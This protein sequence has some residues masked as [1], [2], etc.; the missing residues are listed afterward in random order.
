MS[1]N[2]GE[3]Q[4]ELTDGQET[5]ETSALEA[6]YD[7]AKE[8]IRVVFHEGEPWYSVVDVVGLLTDSSNPRVYW[9]VLKNQIQTE[10]GGQLFR[11]SKQLKQLRMLATD[12]KMRL[13]DAAPEATVLRIIQSVPSPKAEPFKHWLAEVGHAFLEDSRQ[14]L[15]PDEADSMRREYQ[16]LGYSDTWIDARLNGKL[17]RDNLTQEWRERGL[18]ENREF[19]ILTDLLHKLAFAV[20]TAQHRKIK[21]IGAG[22]PLHDSLDAV[23]TAI[24]TLTEATAQRLHIA[25]DSYGFDELQSDARQ[26][27]K[28]GSLARLAFEAE[29]GMPVV[30]STNYKTLRQARQRE[31]QLPLFG[32]TL[33]EPGNSD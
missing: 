9:G 19:A 23:E 22:Q 14:K 18:Q 15:N 16:R 12:G 21:Q 5:Q 25:H 11:D 7:Q 13:T 26:A 1:D 30:N 3:S 32:E 24:Q 27:G 28:V 31:L 17:V 8:R 20:T 10:S 33:P 4:D 6:F 2:Q 29:T